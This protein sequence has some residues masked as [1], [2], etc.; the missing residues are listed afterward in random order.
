[1]NEIKVTSMPVLQ[2]FRSDSGIFE[3]VYR[4]HMNDPKVEILHRQ[5]GDDFY[6][7]LLGYHALGSG[8]YATLCQAKYHKTVENFT[9][10]E[11]FEIFN[12]FRQTDPYELALK[13]LGFDM[14]GM[15]EKCLDHIVWV[16][17][18]TYRRHAGSKA[19]D[20]ELLKSYMQVMYNAGITVVVRDNNKTLR[21]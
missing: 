19:F 15:G 2:S 20:K 7:N 10:K 17:M 11:L 5:Y 21:K 14:E 12:A 3:S 18:C 4:S 1:M 9:Q 8:I 13:S 6:F 16:G